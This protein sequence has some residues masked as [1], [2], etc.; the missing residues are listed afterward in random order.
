MFEQAKLT[1]DF[2]ALEPHIDELTMQTHYGKHHAAYTNNLNSA[3]ERLPELQGKSIEDILI[4]LDSI[5]DASLQ[6]AVRNNGGGFYN[7]NLYFGTL[8]PNGGMEPQGDLGNQIK[9]DFGSFDE[10]KKTLTAQAAAVFG[11]G[12]AWLSTDKDGKLTVTSTPNQDNP[13]M[14]HGGKLTPIFGI[15]VWEHAYYLKYKNVRADYVNAIF[16]VV[17]WDKVAELYL[18]VK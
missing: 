5:S 9:N 11:S 1:Y 7:H 2:N 4:N 12:W 3:L 13:L 8:S 14:T 17:D 15:D 18:K 16:N 6:K 10:L